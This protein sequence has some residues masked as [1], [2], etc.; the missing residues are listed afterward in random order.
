MTDDHLKAA[1]LSRPQSA[2]HLNESQ[3]EQIACGELDAA[4]RERALAHITSCAECTEIHRS[5]LM[6][7]K[8]AAQFDRSVPAANA[9]GG[10]ASKKWMYLTGLAAAAAIFAAIVVMPL[11]PANRTIQDVTRS[12]T[13]SVAIQVTA[14]RVNAT[15]ENR[16]FAWEPVPNADSYQLVVN[17][18]DGG[19][20][21]SVTV[22]DN[23][24]VMP[25]DLPVA[26]GEYYWQVKALSQDTAIG[27]SPLVPFRVR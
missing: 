26:P 19:A 9:P 25:G 12:Q 1:Y 2:A 15:L 5:L 21:W 22:R 4:S 17:R 6:L 20:V 10:S 23:E 27:L 24:T 11:R 18:N 16:R 13:G 3:W 8:E 7:A 14:P